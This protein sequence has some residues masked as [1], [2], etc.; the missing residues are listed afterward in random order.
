M[1]SYV[2][3]ILVEDASGAQFEMHEFVVR[4]GVLDYVRKRTR[5]ALDTGE[6]AEPVDGN[7]FRLTGTGEAFARVHEG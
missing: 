1:T 5:F 3:S 6:E 2:R 4:R 7:T